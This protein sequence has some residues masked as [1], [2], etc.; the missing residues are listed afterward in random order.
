M[1][2]TINMKDLMYLNLFEKITKVRTRSFFEYNNRVYFCVP[3]QFLKQALGEE[4]KNI[5]KINKITGKKVRIVAQPN[6]NNTQEIKK[7]IE[8]IVS[9]VEFKDIEV[10]DKEIKIHAGSMN[11]ASL[12]GKNK[13]RLE[14]MNKITKDYFEKEFKVI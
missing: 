10:T 6:P 8:K 3:K 5:R 12:I 9:P 2:K 11:K 1:I 4:A 13:R 7:F 14:E